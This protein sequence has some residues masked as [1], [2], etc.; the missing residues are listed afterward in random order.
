MRVFGAAVADAGAVRRRRAEHVGTPWS[1]RNSEVDA[2]GAVDIYYSS[3]TFDLAPD[4]A[5][6]DGGHAARRALFANVMLWN[7]HMQT[8]EY[9]T[10]AAR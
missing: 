2:A 7:V 9:R 8:L 10:G 1:F 5:L 6:R 4:E 3:G